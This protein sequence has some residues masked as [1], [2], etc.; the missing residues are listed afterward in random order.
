MRGQCSVS[1]L[2]TREHYRNHIH[3]MQNMPAVVDSNQTRSILLPA[4]LNNYSG[5]FPKYLFW[6]G[7]GH[8]NRSGSPRPGDLGSRGI[9]ILLT[10]LKAYR[11]ATGTGWF[12]SCRS[13]ACA[14]QPL[15]YE[16]QWA[17][18]VVLFFN[19]LSTKSRWLGPQ[20]VRCVPWRPPAWPGLYSVNA[21]LGNEHITRLC[22]Q[23]SSVGP[24]LS[25]RCRNGRGWLSWYWVTYGAKFFAAK[26]LNHFT[27]AY[28]YDPRTL[29]LTAWL[30]FR[31]RTMGVWPIETPTLIRFWPNLTHDEYFSPARQPR[32]ELKITNPA[33]A[34]PFD[35]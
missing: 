25:N 10:C 19:R 14:R 22:I 16:P 15:T 6:P 35:V 26:E 4:Q 2:T 30:W 27:R 8:K 32:Q 24:C 20:L 1:S 13:A 7:T 3:Q 5:D 34:I 21:G 31:S 23:N 11:F 33:Q 9:I 29:S 12:C 17:S 28:G 18:D